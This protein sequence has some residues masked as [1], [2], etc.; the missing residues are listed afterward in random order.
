MRLRVVDVSL[1]LRLP[2]LKVEPAKHPRQIDLQLRLRGMPPQTALRPCRERHKHV[3]HL[4]HH[5]LIRLQPALRQED[6]GVGEVGRAVGVA[7]GCHGDPCAGGEDQVPITQGLLPGDQREMVVCNF[8][9]AEGFGDDRG[10]LVDDFHFHERIRAGH[11]CLQLL[12]ESLHDVGIREGVIDGPAQRPRIRVG[13]GK[14]DL[15]ALMSN[16]YGSFSSSGRE[17]VRRACFG[18]IAAPGASASRAQGPPHNG[19]LWLFLPPPPKVG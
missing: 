2:Q 3:V 5:L 16:T 1:P 18:Q 17:L 10:E 4:R 9:D 7:G 12:P 8:S 13:P 14:E 6:G 15:E 19:S 11:H